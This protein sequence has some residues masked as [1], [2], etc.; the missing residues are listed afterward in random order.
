[1]NPTIENFVGVYENAFSPDY[2]NRVIEQ[3]DHLESQGFTNSRQKLN[4]GT[5]LQKDD[6]AIFTGGLEIDHKGMHKMVG[7]QFNEVFWNECYPHYS[8]HFAALIDADPH[9]IY[10]NKVQKTAVGQGYHVWHFEQGN[11][12]C[13]NRILAYILYLN[14]VDEGGETEFLYQCKRYK[15][16]QGTLVLFPAAFTHTHRGNPPLSNDKYV[17]TGWVEY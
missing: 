15:P 4:D 16:K 7:E 2:C 14:D 1:L 10:C 8:Q 11:R 9:S 17:I 12:H 13:S 5:K 3:F 6:T